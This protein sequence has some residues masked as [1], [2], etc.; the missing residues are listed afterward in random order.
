[1]IGPPS[2]SHGVPVAAKDRILDPNAAKARKEADEIRKAAE[3]FEA[4]L[5]QEMLRSMREAQLEQGFFGEGTGA[6]T[7]QS[8]FEE[9]LSERLAE[10]SPLGIARALEEQWRTGAGGARQAVEAGRRIEEERGR[11]AYGASGAPAPDVG[12]DTSRPSRH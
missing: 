12:F 5:L 1:M 9:H 10:G 6:S 2:S 4:F 7:Y 8:M 3:A 11:R